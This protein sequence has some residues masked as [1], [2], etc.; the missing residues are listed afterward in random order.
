[1]N[2]RKAGSYIQELGA[3]IALVLLAVMI[4]IIRP[5]PEKAANMAEIA[6]IQLV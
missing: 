2:S 6:I 5:N 4:S 1:M 3:L